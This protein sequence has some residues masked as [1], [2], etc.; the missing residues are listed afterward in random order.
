MVDSILNH[1]VAMNTAQHTFLWSTNVITLGS[2]TQPISYI[3]IH[4]LF[5]SFV[6]NKSEFFSGERDVVASCRYGRLDPLSLDFFEHNSTYFP[7]V[8][9]RYNPGIAHLVHFTHKHAVYFNRLF[10]L[11][12]NL[13]GER[14][15]DVVAWCGHSVFDPLSLSCYQHNAT[16][17]P[18]L[19]PHHNADFDKWIFWKVKSSTLVE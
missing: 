4:S 11:N 3:N 10:P 7:T 18:K 14:E 5:Q 1:W 6:Y 13:S 19:N 15:S 12:R 9:P 8:N 16:D 17:F 2:L